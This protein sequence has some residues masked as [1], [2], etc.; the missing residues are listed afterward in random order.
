MWKSF[1]V[2]AAVIGGLSGCA[3]MNAVDNDVSSYSQWTPERKPGPYVFER[4]PSQQAQYKRQD[5]LEA[6]ARGALATAGFAE[7]PDPARADV[8]VQIGAR[9]ERYDVALYDDP[10]WWHGGVFGYGRYGRRGFWG[11]GFMAFP[12]DN[13]RYDREVA[14]LIRDKKSNQVLYEARAANEGAY[15][16]DDRLL[17]AMFEAALKDYPQTGVNPRRIST[18]LSSSK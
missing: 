8:S 10:L 17:A 7:V 6:A 5:R 13:P 2:L 9:I 3:S 4:L 16:G 15:E 1:A 18:Q 14:V 11:P 12:Y